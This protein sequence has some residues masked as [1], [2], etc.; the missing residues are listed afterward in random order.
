MSL[1]DKIRA[2][3]RWV[4]S[5]QIL[6][7]LS[8]GAALAATDPMAIQP[9]LGLGPYPVG[10]S[11]VAQNTMPAQGNL[12]DYWEGNPFDGHY[13]YVTQILTEPADTVGYVLQLP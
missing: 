10:C 13:H 9:P 2:P 3:A 12:S 7:M 11:D 6:W 1:V 4:L 5:S 8:F